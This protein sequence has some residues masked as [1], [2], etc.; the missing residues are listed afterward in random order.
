MNLCLW[1]FF[2][3]FVVP[4]FENRHE[5]LNYTFPSTKDELH[6]QLMSKRVQIFRYDFYIPLV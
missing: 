6:T 4:A 2:Q 5:G 3:V 1:T